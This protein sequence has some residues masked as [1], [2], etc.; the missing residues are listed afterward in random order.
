MRPKRSISPRRAVPRIRPGMN[1]STTDTAAMA[2]A[3][4][5]LPGIALEHPRGRA[6]RIGRP[7]TDGRR[8]EPRERHGED[9]EPEDQASAR[10][11]GMGACDSH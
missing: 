8:R 6:G 5:A 11:Q 4:A 1:A 3:R 9:R 10:E 7:A 2:A